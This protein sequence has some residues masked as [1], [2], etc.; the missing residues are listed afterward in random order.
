MCVC[1]HPVNMRG[2]A[3]V[4]FLKLVP[5]VWDETRVLSGV[6]AE[7]L[8]IA[9]RSGPDWYLGAMNNSY[10]RVRTVKLDFLGPGKWHMRWW[11]D[12]AD[13]GDNA[14]HL[15]IEEKD[16]TA[17]DSLDLRMASAGGAVIRFVPV[18]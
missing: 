8:V 12:A 5:T 4:D 1:D 15:A 14:A 7:H 16:V 3:G 6:V 2:Q 18:P 11:H 13:S 10:A 17:G 9:R